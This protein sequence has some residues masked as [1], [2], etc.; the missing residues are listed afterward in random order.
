M[1]FATRETFQETL[2]GWGVNDDSTLVLYDDSG[3]A[4]AARLYFL[5]DLH[6]FDMEQVKILNGGTVE[7]TGF[8]ELETHPTPPRALGKVT[9]KDANPALFIE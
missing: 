5:L 2:R 4:L 6:G 8:N 9:L 3:T 1:R 7:W